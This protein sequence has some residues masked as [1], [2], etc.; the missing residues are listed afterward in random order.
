MALKEVNRLTWSIM[1]YTTE[2]EENEMKSS[3]LCI[4]SPWNSMTKKVST[5]TC[6]QSNEHHC[7]K[8]IAE[9][10]GVWTRKPGLWLLIISLPLCSSTTD[11]AL[12]ALPLLFHV[13]RPWLLKNHQQQSPFPCA[14]KEKR[15]EKQMHNCQRW[16][17]DIMWCH[18][19]SEYSMSL[20]WAIDCIR[21]LLFTP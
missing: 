5:G 13:F 6:T 12:S 3:A 16:V 20:K 9:I 14:S 18:R 19:W 15:R 2:Y 8:E 4:S 11:I 1:D 17:G 10:E 7:S 21:W